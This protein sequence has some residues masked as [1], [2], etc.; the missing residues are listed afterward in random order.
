M[1][2]AC[3]W[4]RTTARQRDGTGRARAPASSSACP[5]TG[6]STRA[7]AAQAAGADYVAFGSFFPSSVKPG[8]VRAPLELLTQ[9]KRTLTVPVVAIGGITADNGGAARARRR[10]RAGGHLGAVRRG[11]RRTPPHARSAALFETCPMKQQQRA[12][13]PISARHARR[14]ELARARVSL[15][16][17]HAAFFQR[18]KGAAGVGRRRQRATSTTSARGGRSLLGHA[19]PEVV[20]AVAARCR[21]R[22][23]SFGAPTE[24]EARD[25]GAARASSCLRSSRCVW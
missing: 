13:R 16:G 1:P 6:T 5:A 20:E 15:G 10:R 19:H 23:L 9:A 8:A 14:R 21:T 2:T 7:R 24:L 22:A 4:A 25:G 3:I 12:L 17:R 11:G 18:G